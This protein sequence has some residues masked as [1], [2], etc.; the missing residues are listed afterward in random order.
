MGQDKYFTDRFVRII[1]L[2]KPHKFYVVPNDFPLV[3]EG[4]IGL[5]CLE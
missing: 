4:I 5:P 2:G 3:E 1:I